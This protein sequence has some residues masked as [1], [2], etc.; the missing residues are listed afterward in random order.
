[1]FSM[2]NSIQ[3]FARVQLLQYVQLL[4]IFLCFHFP[5]IFFR[6]PGSFCHYNNITFFPHA[7]R[8]YVTQSD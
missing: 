8:G 1:M 5:N 6:S 3:P 4:I 7:C 2:F